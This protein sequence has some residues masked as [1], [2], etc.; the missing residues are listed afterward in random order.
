M[1][2]LGAGYN[3]LCDAPGGVKKVYIFATTDG[4]GTDTVEAFTTSNGSVTDLD[5]INGQKAYTFNVE[6]ETATFTVDSVGEKTAGSNAYSHTSTVVLHGNTASD[7]VEIDNLDKGRHAVI[8][9]LTDGTYELLH[10]DNG[11]KCQSSRTPGTL[12]EDMNGTTLTFTSKET[13]PAYKISST[14]VNAL[15]IPDS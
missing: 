2:E 15:L 9:Q 10:M 11:A 12:Y 3:D 5:L 13:I 7:I 1:C 8:H 4:S 14:I 6:Q